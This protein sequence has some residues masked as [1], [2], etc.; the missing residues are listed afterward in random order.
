MQPPWRTRPNS[1]FC[2]SADTFWNWRATF[3]QPHVLKNVFVQY[4]WY[5]VFLQVAGTRAP[6]GL[7][8]SSSLGAAELPRAEIQ[9][10]SA[11]LKLISGGMVGMVSQ[12][13]PAGPHRRQ[14]AN[15]I[16][17]EVTLPSFRE[18]LCYLEHSSKA[19]TSMG[20]SLATFCIRGA[21]LKIYLDRCKTVRIYHLCFFNKNLSNIHR[22]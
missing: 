17:R 21:Y 13:F 7:V 2:K 14:S 15:V 3:A 22:K 12:L 18:A 5:Y 1:T 4:R 10:F 19:R 16:L 9:W 20:S 8:P 6:T 11:V